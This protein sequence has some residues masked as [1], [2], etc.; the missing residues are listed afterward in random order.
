MIGGDLL[1]RAAAQPVDA[2]VADVRD[3]DLAA[4]EHD[5]A[6]RGAHA[7]ELAVLEDRLGEQEFAAISADCNAN[8]ASCGEE[9]VWSAS[10]TRWATIAEAT[11]PPAWP[12]M[13]SATRKR[14]EPA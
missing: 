2:R 6:R 4:D 11:S 9:Y 8:S 10:A 14:W 12:P 5:P 13:P 1:E 7:G 3:D